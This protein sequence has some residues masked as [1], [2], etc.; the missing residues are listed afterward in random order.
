MTDIKEEIQR[1]IDIVTLV[2]SYVALKKRGSRYWGLC[3]FH[4]EKT[5]SFCVTP[6]KDLYYCFGCQKGGDLF[7]FFMEMERCDFPEA[8]RML[9]EK[10]G[11]EYRPQRGDGGRNRA[12]RELHAKVSGSFHYVLAEREEAEKARRYLRERGVSEHTVEEFKLGYAPES[13]EWLLRFLRSKGYSIEFLKTSGLFTDRG[14]ELLPLFRDRII[15]PIQNHRGEVVAFGGRALAE[16][17]P[18]YIN[19]PETAIFRKGEHLYGIHQALAAVRKEQAFILVEGYM[20]VLALSQAGLKNSVAPL[21]TALTS[22]QAR[23]LKRYADK[24][25]LLFDGDQAGENAAVKAIPLLEGMGFRV[26]AVALPEGT[27]PADLVQVRGAAALKGALADGLDGFRYLLQ[28]AGRRHDIDTPEGKEG[29]FRFFLPLLHAVPSET[30]REGFL[31]ELAD[32]LNVDSAAVRRD[33]E[34]SRRPAQST[35]GSGPRS[36]PRRTVSEDLYLM[37]AVSANLEY[38]SEVRSALSADDL[39]DERAKQLYY[40]LEDCYRKDLVS[41]ENVLE[42]LDDAEVRRRIMEKVSSEEFST[43]AAVVIRDAVKSIQRRKLVEKRAALLHD[44][45]SLKG[46]DVDT[47]R[48]EKELQTEII[49]LNDQLSG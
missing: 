13:R 45:K 32:A 4:E 30:R 1:R 12:L 21:G 6:E 38:F 28:A 11:V 17:V 7:G 14:A 8:L 47:M 33:F 46:A 2:S 29:V 40:S 5:P 42:H 39:L 44:L 16:G 25:V 43:N 34:R 26:T 31:A 24:T 23:L 15:F 22:P 10:V 48:R 18:K 19:S 3:P 37:I 35:V 9:A 20:D 36:A 27:D 49:V 41:L